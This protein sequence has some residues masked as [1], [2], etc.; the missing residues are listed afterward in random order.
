MGV[1]G[2][3]PLIS[4]KKIPYRHDTEFFIVS[5]F[6]TVFFIYYIIVYGFCGR[7]GLIFGEF[8]YMAI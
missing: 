2:S 6:T 5:I 3:S 1:G 4:T 8:A 7:V